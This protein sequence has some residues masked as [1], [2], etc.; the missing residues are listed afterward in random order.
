MHE[1]PRPLPRS[2]F[3]HVA[4]VTTRWMDNDAYGHLNNVV[5]YSLFD[6]AVNAWLIGAGVLDVQHGE[7]VAFVVETRCH[8]FAPLA[9][10]QPVEV[11]LRAVELGRSSVRYAIGVFAVGAA[12]T[13]AHGEF[14]HVCVDRATE[15]PVPLPDALRRAL[16]SLQ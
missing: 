6:T 9:F 1:R 2:A 13:A 4:P 14:V 12:E 8:Y 3:R 15:R 10:P 5:Y 11:G 7:T 16:E